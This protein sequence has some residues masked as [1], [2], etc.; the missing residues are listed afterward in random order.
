MQRFLMAVMLGVLSSVLL[1]CGDDGGSTTA[2]ICDSTCGKV[3]EC[4]A[5]PG[6]VTQESC[7]E[8]CVSE[9]GDLVCDQVNE[10]N[11]AS[12]LAGIESLSC[13]ALEAGQLPSVCN[14]VCLVRVRSFD[15]SVV[16]DQF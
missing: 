6:D 1:G 8:T 4:V 14:A 3:L 15:P 11:L 9:F 16:L 2:A 12:C 5:D 13:A 7:T 10:A